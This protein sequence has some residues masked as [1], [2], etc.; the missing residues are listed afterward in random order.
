M[1]VTV[2]SDGFITVGGTNLSSRCTGFTVK[3]GY[4]TIDLKAMSNTAGNTGIGMADQGIS[5]TFLQDYAAGSTHATLQAALGT[6]VAVV[7]RPTSAV[8][9]STNPQWSGTLLLAA[10]N[11][12][13]AK[14]GDKYEVSVDF[15]TQGTALTRTP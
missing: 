13:G 11:P 7:V 5:A 4:S 15:L 9:G 12:I 8:A 3:D 14:V 10:Y 2:F 1:A 6:G